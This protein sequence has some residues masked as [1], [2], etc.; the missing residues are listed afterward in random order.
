MNHESVNTKRQVDQVGKVQDGPNAN[1]EHAQ[2]KRITADPENSGGF[3]FRPFLRDAIPQR[4][5]ELKNR[6]DEEDTPYD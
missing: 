2:V 5:S 4:A 6:R 3:E 1:A